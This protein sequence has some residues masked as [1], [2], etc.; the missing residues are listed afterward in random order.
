MS[1]E[2]KKIDLYYENEEH[3]LGYFLQKY[4]L[5]DD[6]VIYAGYKVPHPQE[7]K[8]YIT[9]ELK[10]G[11]IKTLNNIVENGIKDLEIIKQEFKKALL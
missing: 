3:T 10:D 6:N 8:L 11:S 2:Q 5:N 7:R 1:T 4:L 9:Y